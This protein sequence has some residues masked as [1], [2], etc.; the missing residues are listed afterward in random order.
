MKKTLSLF[1][2]LLLCLTLA[3]P[4]FAAAPQSAEDAEDL[5]SIYVNIDNPGRHLVKHWIDFDLAS[6]KDKQT[7]SVD[8]SR[9]TNS[10]YVFDSNTK[11]T[12]A[13]NDESDDNYIWLRIDCFR[14]GANGRYIS[15]YE[16]D[17]VGYSLRKNGE[18]IHRTADDSATGSNPRLE[19]KSGEEI[20]FWTSEF[21]GLPKDTVYMLTI[22]HDYPEEDIRWSHRF[23]FVVDDARAAK[24]AAGQTETHETTSD[25]NNPFSDVPSNA[26]YHDAVLWA[27]ENDITAG[28]SATTFDPF[29]TCTRGQVVTFL[30][31]ASGCPDPFTLE[32]PFK[33]VKPTDYYY[34][35]VLWAYENGITAGNTATTFAPND[36][37]TSA[38]V[39]TFLWRANGCP[40]A[41]YNG[42]KY[43]GKAVAWANANNLLSGMTV[44]FAPE[45]L[46]PRADIVTYL[47]RNYLNN[48]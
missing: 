28:T 46:S 43:Y 37:C 26:Y 10:Y 11:L 48:L 44:E 3:A 2:A 42:M 13:N 6:W 15:T 27:L 36:R 4:A 22:C 23:Y 8:V 34:K 29:T 31:R 19:A 40:D 38:H 21:A 33:D 41:E 1:L 47:Y 20:V 18:F 24:L 17:A 16:S 45:N 12:I 39:I 9:S 14:E 5:Y 7:Y 30:W 32:N 35:A 25:G